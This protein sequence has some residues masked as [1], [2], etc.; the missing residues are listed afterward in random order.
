MPTQ[1]NIALILYHGFRLYV[2]H[3][4]RLEYDTIFSSK[5]SY[6]KKFLLEF[7]PKYVN[8]QVWMSKPKE[9]RDTYLFNY[10]FVEVPTVGF[11]FTPLPPYLSDISPT[12]IRD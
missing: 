7:F 4:K 5:K 1:R 11:I 10:Y 8:H 3:T 12:Y 9:K 6:D 2:H